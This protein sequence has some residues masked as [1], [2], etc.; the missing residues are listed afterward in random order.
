MANVIRLAAILS[1]SALML[2]ACDDSDNGGSA[3]GDPQ[4]EFGA[5]FAQAFNADG[6]DDAIDP[7]LGDAG[8]LSLTDDPVNF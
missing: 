6:T 1:V 3:N 8:E 7:A 2:A 5:T 4:D